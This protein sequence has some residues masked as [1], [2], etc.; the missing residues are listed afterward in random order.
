MRLID[1]D[2]LDLVIHVPSQNNAVCQQIADEVG[3][4]IVNAPTVEA[5]PIE[6][7]RNYIAKQKKALRLHDDFNDLD[8]IW[9]FIGIETLLE[10]WEAEN[11]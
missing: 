4:Q 10:D 9:E 7:I 3:R 6:W 8:V 1:A 2:S 11:G 5:I